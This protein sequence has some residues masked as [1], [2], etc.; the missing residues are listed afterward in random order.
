MTTLATHPTIPTPATLDE[1]VRQSVCATISSICGGETLPLA[2]GR[3]EDRFDG[4]CGIIPIA[5]D[6]VCSF[7]LGLPRETA[8][9]LV[10]T[11][12]GCDIDFDSPDMGDAVGELAN[13]MAGDFIARLDAAGV[14]A[15]LS[16]PMVAR[17]H[18]VELLLPSEFPAFRIAFTAPVGACWAKL[19]TVQPGRS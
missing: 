11:F 6:L 10:T 18:N 17:G 14:S 16:I 8:T 5:G 7:V 19:A 12:A 13:I 9:H 2:A 4:L 15:A 1:Y 3:D